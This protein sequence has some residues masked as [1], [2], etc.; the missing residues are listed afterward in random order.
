MKTVDQLKTITLL[1][2]QYAE[3]QTTLA[4]AKAARQEAFLER[5]QA[6]SK[7][8][9]GD[10]TYQ[11]LMKIVDLKKAIKPAEELYCRWFLDSSESW[12]FETPFPETEKVL[13]PLVDK[14]QKVIDEAVLMGHTIARDYEDKYACIMDDA[15]K[16]IKAA[17]E[18]CD[19]IQEE[20][21]RARETL[22]FACDDLPMNHVDIDNVIHNLKD[23]IKIDNLIDAAVDNNG[24]IMVLLNGTTEVTSST[25]VDECD[26]Y[27]NLDDCP[28]IN[29]DNAISDKLD[30]IESS[31]EYL[32]DKYD[33]L[34]EDITVDHNVDY[35]G[36]TTYHPAY[37]EHDTGYSEPEGDFYYG[38]CGA[39]A[40]VDVQI[41][42]SLK[43]V[44]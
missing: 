40:S 14:I 15:D 26:C 19:K 27:E 34:V 11:G 4:S 39:T 24:N 20:L 42:I 31:L 18:V 23:I 41:T 13:R 21:T 3:A 28:N 2:G 6:V 8:L 7:E 16:K 5:S 43:E 30:S 1:N 36:A 38:E 35:Y 10:M 33:I 29:I 44:K 22:K 9:K 17:K 37:Y 25:N 12:D 32:V